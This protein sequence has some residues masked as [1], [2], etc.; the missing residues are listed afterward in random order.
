[1]KYLIR[2][3][4]FIAV[5]GLLLGMVEDVSAAGGG[6]EVLGQH[7]VRPGETL[8][9]I[10]R[11]YGVDP[12]AIGTQNDLAQPSRIYSGMVLA[13]PDVAAEMPLGPVCAP[14]LDAAA[15][16]PPVETPAPDSASPPLPAPPLCGGCTCEWMHIVAAGD[17]LTRVS[18]LYGRDVWTIA[19]CNCIQ[20]V[21]FIR[22][23][24]LLCIP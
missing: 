13:I 22:T 16:V 8:Y 15:P 11:A 21:N 17:T 23:G 12:W 2:A 4:L 10:G 9:C 5:G 7:T 1:M 3:I 18:L 20:N 24:D 6:W 14:Q 19:R